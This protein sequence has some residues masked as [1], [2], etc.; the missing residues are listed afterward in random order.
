MKKHLIIFLFPALVLL[1]H[2]EGRAQETFKTVTQKVEKTFEFNYKF[3]QILIEAE[4]GNIHIESW[5]RDEIS[6]VLSISAKN[7]NMELAKQELG[8]MR[9]NLVKSRGNVFL[10]NKMVLPETGEQIK[11]S[12]VIS[13]RY[14]IRVPENTDIR[15]NNK[16]GRCYH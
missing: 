12:S 7:T 15:I 5:D 14:E 16:F 4:R 9:Y 3:G 13:A 2:R 1:T 11:I 10:N 6:I 8:Y